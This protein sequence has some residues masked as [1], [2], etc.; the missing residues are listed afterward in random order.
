MLLF[1]FFF[2]AFYLSETFQVVSSPPPRLCFLIQKRGTNRKKTA[3]TESSL[4]KN[5]FEAYC[6]VVIRRFG[7]MPSKASRGRVYIENWRGDGDSTTFI[8]IAVYTAS[9]VNKIDEAEVYFGFAAVTAATRNVFIF[10]F[11][12][13]KKWTIEG[14]LLCRRKRSR[15]ASIKREKKRRKMKTIYYHV[16]LV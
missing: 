10:F 13:W 6:I 9:V 4:K 1:S 12:W 8:F 14:K 15:T 16:E 3:Q 7:R 11:T 5:V 2:L